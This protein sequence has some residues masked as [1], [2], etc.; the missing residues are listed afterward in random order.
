V[1]AHGFGGGYLAAQVVPA[2]FADAQGWV[3]GQLMV[4]WLTALLPICQLCHLRALHHVDDILVTVV[5]CHF[6]G[7]P[8]VLLSSMHLNWPHRWWRLKHF[9]QF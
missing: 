3:S 2:V 6:S 1:G 5:V 8:M 9:R 4:S 7:R